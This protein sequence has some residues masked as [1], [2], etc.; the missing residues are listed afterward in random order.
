MNTRFDQYF[1]WLMAW[2]GESFENVA[3][4]RGGAT[5]YGI[6]QKNHPDVNIRKLTRPVAK[7]IYFHD[8]WTPVRA[9][10][11]AAPLDWIMMDIA[12]NNGRQ[13]AIKWLQDA[14]GERVDGVFG[15]LTMGRLEK[16]GKTMPL[17]DM[18]LRRRETFYHDIV[19][20]DRTQKKFLKGWMARV[21]SY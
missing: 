12:V 18:M 10:D 2:E 1:E 15:P 4:D 9:E 3:G 7:E 17:C 21:N 14:L 5:K 8:Y 6:D 20:C 19:E 13:R 16:Y 11:V